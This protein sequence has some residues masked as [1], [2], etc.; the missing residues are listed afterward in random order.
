MGLLSLLLFILL[1]ISLLISNNLSLYIFNLE[2]NYYKIK[3]T[4]I[5][6]HCIIKSKT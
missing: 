1:K 2:L 3:N 6:C 5:L 4:N